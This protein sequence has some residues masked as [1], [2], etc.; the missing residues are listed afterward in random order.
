MKDIKKVFQLARHLVIRIPDLTL[1]HPGKMS[2]IIMSHIN[3]NQIKNSL[4]PVKRHLLFSETN[5]SKSR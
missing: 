2:T 3:E 5:A 4:Y 1:E